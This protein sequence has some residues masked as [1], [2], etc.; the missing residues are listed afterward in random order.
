MVETT[1]GIVSA[2]NDGS[3]IVARVPYAFGVLC[4]TTGLVSTVALMPVDSVMF[5]APGF[6][7]FAWRNESTGAYTYVSSGVALALN[8]VASTCTLAGITP[9]AAQSPSPAGQVVV[10]TGTIPVG[11]APGTVIFLFRRVRYEFKASALVSGLNGLW[12]TDLTTGATQELAAPVHSTARFRYYV[13]GSA[14]AQTTPPSPISNIRGIE[15][16]LDGRS[17]TVGR[18][19]ANARVMPLRASVFFQN[20]AN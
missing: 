15:A 6:A 10:L 5:T 7:G 4:A 2:A 12:R 13:A 1:G 19:S 18:M 17:E 20:T 3:E 11:T 14:T 16:A 8:G 9:V